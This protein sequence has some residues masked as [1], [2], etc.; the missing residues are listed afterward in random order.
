MPMLV[1]KRSATAKETM[2]R[3]SLVLASAPSLVKLPENSPC[4]IHTFSASG[5]RQSPRLM[6]VQRPL[7]CFFAVR[8]HPSSSALLDIKLQVTFKLCKRCLTP[9][10]RTLSLCLSH[11]PSCEHLLQSSCHIHQLCGTLRQLI[12]LST[13]HFGADS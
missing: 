10:W 1:Q 13:G 11:Q 6:L 8:Q 12:L 7:D 4:R 9:Q 3:H 2:R 5:A